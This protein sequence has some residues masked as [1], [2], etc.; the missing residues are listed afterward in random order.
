MDVLFAFGHGLSYTTF[1]Y[2]DLEVTKADNTGRGGIRVTLNVTNS[3]SMKGREIVQ[4]YVADHT[5]SIERPPQELKGFETVTLDPG[6]MKPVSFELD[7]R[8]FSWYDTLHKIWYAAD[9]LYEIRIG[10]SSRQIELTGTVQLTG[11]PERMPVF[12]DDLTIG[13]LLEYGPTR[14]Y[15]LE[16]LVQVGYLAPG[17]TLDDADEMTR[18]VTNAVPLSC[19]KSYTPITDA[20]LDQI[21]RDLKALIP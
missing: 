16:L 6:E 17:T 7:E 14:D 19:L 4:L 12:D 20:Q 5:G 18:C 9:G 21:I 3:G 1:K 2:S 11:A 10:K 8:A 15:I 13:E